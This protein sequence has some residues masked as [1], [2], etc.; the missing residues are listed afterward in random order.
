MKSIFT[1]CQFYSIL[2]DRDKYHKRPPISD[3]L[4]SSSDQLEAP[5]TIAA[6]SDE[7]TRGVDDFDK[8]FSS[9]SPNLDTQSMLIAGIRF[10]ELPVVH[11]HSSLNNTIILVSDHTCEFITSQYAYIIHLSLSYI[12]FSYLPVFYTDFSLQFAN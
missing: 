6:T 3:E 1:S 5:P 8:S 9:L 7:I 11:I 12:C 2:Q 4:A 10:D